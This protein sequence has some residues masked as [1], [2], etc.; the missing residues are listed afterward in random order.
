MKHGQAI[1]KIAHPLDI[2]APLM[3][4]LQLFRIVLF[5]H[6]IF[7]LMDGHLEFLNGLLKGGGESLMIEDKML[8]VFFQ[9]FPDIAVAKKECLDGLND[10]QVFLLN[11]LF[12]RKRL[13]PLLE[14][15]MKVF[16]HL[17]QLFTKGATGLTSVLV[18]GMEGRRLF[19]GEGEGYVVLGRRR[20]I[21]RPD[22]VQDLLKELE[23]SQQLEDGR[24]TW[25]G[26]EE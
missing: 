11:V 24:H 6:R 2:E 17:A 3:I 26:L 23:T 12:G 13:V 15:C 1:A 21:R 25:K 10:I 8:I 9:E 16:H 7:D 20:R 5:G 14:M 22:A 19:G 18:N 4:F